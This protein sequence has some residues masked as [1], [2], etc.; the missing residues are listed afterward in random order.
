MIDTECPKV[1]VLNIQIEKRRKKKVYF[2]FEGSIGDLLLRAASKSSNPS[3]SFEDL[4]VLKVLARKIK[5]L[6]L[7]FNGLYT[8]SVI[9]CQCIKAKGKEISHL[10]GKKTQLSSKE[11]FITM[12]DAYLV[13]S[14]TPWVVPLALSSNNPMAISSIIYNEMYRIYHALRFPLQRWINESSKTS[15][16][17]VTVDPY[18]VSDRMP[19]EITRALEK[20]GLLQFLKRTRYISLPDQLLSDL[21]RYFGEI[22]SRKAFLERRKLPGQMRLGS[23]V[24]MI[25]KEFRILV[26]PNDIMRFLRDSVCYEDS[27]IDKIAKGYLI[28]DYHSFTERLENLGLATIR[29][30]GDVM[31]RIE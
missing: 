29:P 1:G 12:R 14:E 2:G 9:D 20:L 25:K 16:A 28:S 8:S 3:H 26:S 4:V 31:I 13:H 17:I 22:T 19:R 30:D 6:G 27:G 23:F 10:N 21:V 7:V 11:L 15:A 24:E 18:E 5:N